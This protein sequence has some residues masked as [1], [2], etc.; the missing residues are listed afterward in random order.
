VA[1]TTETVPLV[2][3][4]ALACGV[5]VVST[6]VGRAPELLADGDAGALYP[7]G[8]ARRLAEVLIDWLRAPETV[9]RRR[10]VA[11]AL[12]EAR[13]PLAQGVEQ[14]AG[15]IARALAEDHAIVR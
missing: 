7:W 9:T 11:R 1:S 2:L 4:E 10:A 13:L 6:P 8:D 12:A 3:L 5:P 15:L 14:V